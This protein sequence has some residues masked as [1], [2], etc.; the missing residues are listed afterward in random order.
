ME[1]MENKRKEPVKIYINV[2]FGDVVNSSVAQGGAGNNVSL[3]LPYDL[4][5]ALLDGMQGLL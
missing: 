5:K 1:N 4:I 2:I 3:E